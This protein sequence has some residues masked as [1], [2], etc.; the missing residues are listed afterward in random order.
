MSIRGI[1]SFGFIKTSG[2]EQLAF[3]DSAKCLESL[4]AV[5]GKLLSFSEWDISGLER[6]QGL[7]EKIITEQKC[8]FD[9]INGI[10]KELIQPLAKINPEIKK[11]E[12][13][14]LEIISQRFPD[15][16]ELDRLSE[17]SSLEVSPI[18]RELRARLY[19]S[20]ISKK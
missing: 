13:Q 16:L 10:L 3:E 5:L 12:E 8:E 19:N 2:A 11:C 4:K 7:L 9:E 6:I 14:V 1:G 18:I 15:E 20:M 17:D